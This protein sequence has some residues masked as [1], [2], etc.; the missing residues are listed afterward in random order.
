MLT[1]QSQDFLEKLRIELLFRGKT[2]AEVEEL[3]EELE[4]H[5]T[6][7]EKNNEDTSSIINTPIKSMADQLSPEISLTT[8]LY[9]YITLY[10]SFILAVIIIPRFLDLGTF[11]VTIAFLLYIA[12]IVILGVVIGMLIL[13]NT[14][15]RFG[16]QKITYVINVT[17]GIVVFLWMIF[18]GLIIKKYPIYSFFELSDK[19]SFIVGLV[20]LIKQKI[21]ALIVLVISLPSLIARIAAI[22]SKEPDTFNLVSVSI[23][24]ILNIAFIIYT[25]VNFRKLKKED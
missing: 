10:F 15:V 19:Q 11:D 14:L 4:D 6:M 3:L 24:I 5:L 7:A 12:S 8:G 9:K 16:D 18:G 2:E 17:Y 21:Y 1:K 25:F 20:L 22:F 13:R 23:L